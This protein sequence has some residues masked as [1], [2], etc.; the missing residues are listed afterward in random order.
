MKSNTEPSAHPTPAARAS[1]ADPAVGVRG[2]AGE[3]APPRPHTAG[4][5]ALTRPFSPAPLRPPRLPSLLALLDLPLF[6][7]F[8]NVKQFRSSQP[9]H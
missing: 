2:E 8:F 6:I 9:L 1:G 7:F 5:P 3:R 4:N